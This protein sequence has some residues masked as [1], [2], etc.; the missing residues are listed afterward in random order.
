MYQIISDID[1]IIEAIENEDN[2][3]AIYMLKEI[4]QELEFKAIINGW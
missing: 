1:I 3:D 4:K 2:R